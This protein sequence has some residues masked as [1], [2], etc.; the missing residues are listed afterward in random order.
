M[1]A[2]FLSDSHVSGHDD[3]N[4][5][6]LIAFLESLSG[7][8]DR[9]FLVGDV[10][11]TWFAFPRAVFDEYVPLLGVLHALHRAGTAITYITGNHD[12]EPGR[13]MSEILGAEVRDTEMTLEADGHRAFVS[14]G[15]LVNRGDRRYRVM[16]RILRN[17]VT[18]WVARRVPPAVVWRVGRAMSD[19]YAGDHTETRR[20]LVP[21]FKD[22]ASRKFQE[23]FTTVILGHL[24][25]PLFAREGS[26]RISVNL[27]DWVQ[28]RTFLRWH[29]GELV[30]RQWQ[31]PEGSEKD[32]TPPE[33]PAGQ[34]GDPGR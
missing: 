25:I 8:V 9:L 13:Y 10:F 19:T 24:H 30:L 15:D 2:V 21:V 27:G 6:A 29:D 4:L 20:R 3:P 32:F 34:G 18:R 33:L 31:W 28:W 22:F 16:R 17:P 23:G 14:H 11:D 1:Q 7:R 26:G 5:P 12:F